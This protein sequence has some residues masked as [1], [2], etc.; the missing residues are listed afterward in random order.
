MKVLEKAQDQI[1]KAPRFSYS[2]IT[3]LPDEIENSLGDEFT[4]NDLYVESYHEKR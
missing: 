1:I 2:E 4:K 3:D